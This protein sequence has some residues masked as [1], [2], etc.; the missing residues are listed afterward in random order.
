MNIFRAL[1]G[2]KEKSAGEEKQHEREK[3]FDVLKFDG[4]RALRSG[5]TAYAIKCFTHALEMKDDLETRDYLSQALIR[6]DEL[7][8]AFEQL[9]KLAEAQPEN[10]EIFIR[11]AHVAYMME[12]YGAMTDACERALF[13]NKDDPQVLFLYA[14]G[15]IGQGDQANAIAMLTKCITLSNQQPADGN[16][17]PSFANDARLLRGQTL[18]K[19]GEVAEAEEDAG[20]LMEQVPGNE[21]VLL[22]KA[23][24]EEAKSDHAKAADYYNKVIEA[25]PFCVDAF[26]ERSAVRLAMGDHEGAEEDM[27]S[28]LE[29][30]PK[31]TQNSSD[32]SSSS[33]LADIQRKVEQAYRDNN[34]FG[35]G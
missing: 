31:E 16:S 14:Q 34:P 32:A 11:M 23:R 25:N 8:P 12:D 6:N 17:H 21:D 24:I 15:C 9:Q 26:R 18:L 13:I 2:G 4:V 3:D 33:D 10:E 30:S 20:I 28:V 29:L 27:Q 7:L 5:E 22:L 35:L 1:F 19:L